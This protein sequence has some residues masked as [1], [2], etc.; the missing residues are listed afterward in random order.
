[1]EVS[2]AGEERVVGGYEFQLGNYLRAHRELNRSC[3]ELNVQIAEGF[4]LCYEVYLE[5]TL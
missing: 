4:I 2:E 1:M 3:I 5:R